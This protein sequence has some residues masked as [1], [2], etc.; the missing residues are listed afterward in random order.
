MRVPR[1]LLGFPARRAARS[2]TVASVG[3]VAVDARQRVELL[4]EL[5]LSTLEQ[6]SII[7]QGDGGVAVPHLVSDRQR[8]RP[9]VDQERCV[10]VPN[11]IGADRLGQSR[12]HEGRSG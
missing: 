7:A 1:V 3:S 8:A 10:R 4:G 2:V 12:R 5:G 9:E 6:V 11:V